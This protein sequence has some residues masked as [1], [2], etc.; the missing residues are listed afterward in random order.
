MQ[1]NTGQAPDAG[2]PDRSSADTKAEG[3]EKSLDDISGNSGT[4]GTKA[5]EVDT[6][7]YF[8]DSPA[9]DMDKIEEAARVIREGGLVAFPTETVYGLGANA[10]MPS[11][12]RRLFEVKGRP[13]GIP[14]AIHLHS[15]HEV[16]RF[17]KRLPDSAIRLMTQFLPGPLMLVLESSDEV[18]DIVTGGTRKVG[19]RVIRHQVGAAIIEKAGVP[20]AATSANLSG[21]FS[22]VTARQVWEEL[23]GRI[24]MIIETSEPPAGIES[25]IIDLT[26]DVARILRP[27]FISRKEI[28]RILGI[29]PQL[30]SDFWKES[31]RVARPHSGEIWLMRAE[32][33]EMVPLIGRV[34]NENKDKRLMFLVSEENAGQFKDLGKVEIL[35]PGL[36]QNEAATSIFTTL[37][38]MYREDFDLM[39]IE[40]VDSSKFGEALADRL[41]RVANRTV[42]PTDIPHPAKKEETKNPADEETILLE[43]EE[44][45]RD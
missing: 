24:D 11:A 14:V 38:E 23:G 7:I 19:I 5:R 31:R 9:R 27:G 6:K 17:V 28:G 26:T 37:R 22:A 8:V 25:T 34:V 39:I 40:G 20:V 32:P 3:G 42:T 36:G 10:L 45:T 44:T 13:E 33:S 15:V 1:N 30:S 4:T 41:S 16:D 12:V 29:E 21:S 2:F 18:P 35:R 43:D